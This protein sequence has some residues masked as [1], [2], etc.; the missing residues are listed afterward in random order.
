MITS[1]PL[2]ASAALNRQRRATVTRPSRGMLPAK[3]AKG[4]RRACP[5]RISCQE[6]PALEALATMREWHSVVTT[7]SAYYHG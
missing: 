7:M 2:I 5:Q 4:L 6:L 3:I 1:S